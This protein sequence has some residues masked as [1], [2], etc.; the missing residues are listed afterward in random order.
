MQFQYLNIFRFVTSLA[1]ILLCVI[2]CIA[3]INP[4]AF[5]AAQGRVDFGFVV[6]SLWL[7]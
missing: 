1:S 5:V 3:T 7:W 2:R 4:F 6:V